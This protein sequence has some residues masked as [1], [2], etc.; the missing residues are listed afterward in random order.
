MLEGLFCCG[1]PFVIA[2]VIFW[3][4][5]SWSMRGFQSAI[6]MD[7][8]TCLKADD[9]SVVIR[10]HTT[11]NWI[12]LV[13]IL[14]L[15]LPLTVVIL[16]A[17]IGGLVKGESDL[18][19]ALETLGVAVGAGSAIGAGVFTLVRSMRRPSVCFNTQ[20]RMTESGHGASVRQIPFADV[21]NVVV[22][23]TNRDSMGKH[24]TGVFRVGVILSDGSR[25][26]LGTV[27][28]EVAKAKERAVVIAGQIA[29]V[30]GISRRQEED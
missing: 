29:D 14:G 20:A 16:W 1:I 26:S 19:G 4:W 6:G 27:S 7:G 10:R 9:G 21:V 28:G 3:L 25:L 15:G 5:R 11:R 17:A 12:A 2:G 23:L 13:V 24:E 30:T 8:A 22:E 18:V